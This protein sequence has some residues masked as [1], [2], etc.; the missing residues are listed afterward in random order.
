ME[1]METVLDGG[2]ALYGS[3][4]VAGVVNLVPIKE[5]EGVKFRSYYQRPEDGKNEDMRFS[6]LFGKSWNNGISYVGAV[7]TYLRTPLMWY[8]R[9]RR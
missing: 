3:D 4:A 7:E 9:G 1:R 2:S 8:E 5:L 6:A